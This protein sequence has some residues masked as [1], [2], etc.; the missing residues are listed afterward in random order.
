[1]TGNT[2]KKRAWMDIKR[3]F[4]TAE[5]IQELFAKYQVPR[6]F[7]LLSID[8]D[9]NDYW[10]WKAVVDY[11][12]RV[13]AIEY[14]A[15]VPPDQARTIAYEP[16]FIWKKTDYMGAS[17]LALEKLGKEKGY[18]LVG[19]DSC[20]TN[21]FFVDSTLA[22]H[23]VRHSVSELFRPPGYHGGKGHPPDPERKMIEV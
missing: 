19:C 4:I 14:N 3:E 7:D 16:S 15:M 9:G 13:V 1:M 10:V 18:T 5:N 17:L 2:V 22:Q 12:P 8:I 21:A 23:F 6:E 11:R 20:G